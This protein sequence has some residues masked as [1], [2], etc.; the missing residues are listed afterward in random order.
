MRYFNILYKR[1]KDSMGFLHKLTIV[2]TALV[3]S[4]ISLHIYSIKTVKKDRDF[5]VS[6]VMNYDMCQM[7][8]R[9]KE[10]HNY[11]DAD[12]KI[13]EKEFKRYFILVGVK[14]PDQGSLG[15]YSRDVDNLWH[16]FILFTK[17]YTH[18]CNNTFGRYIHHI[19]RIK[20][21]ET[22]EDRQKVRNNFKNFIQRYESFFGE[23]IH[24]IWL[25]D[26]CE[27]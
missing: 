3:I 16:M 15:M 20:E 25:L 22:L 21:N 7:I 17:E 18:F 14:E 5:V 11:S 27:K 2:S 19:P 24:P 4:G 26:A 1:S 6:A 23:D 9:C 10:D 12:M 13:I 8:N